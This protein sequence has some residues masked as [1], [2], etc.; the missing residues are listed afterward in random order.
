MSE[1]KIERKKFNWKNLLVLLAGPLTVLIVMLINFHSNELF[2]F[3]N[4]TVA[5]CDMTQ[6][7]IPLLTD[8]KDILSGKAGVFLNFQNAGGM[9]LWGVIFFF[10]ASP[11]TFLVAF[12]KK[13][14]IVYLVNIL[15]ILKLM[16][17]A[18]TAEIYL[19]SCIKKLSPVFAVMLSVVYA[20][21]GYGMLFYQ[22][23]IWLD[24]MYLFP[25]L[26]WS[27]NCLIERKRILPYVIVLTLMM[28]VNYYI[29][30][31]VVLYILLF[32][33]LYCFRY[34]NGNNGDTQVSA[35]FFTG[36]FL[37]ALI[38]AVVW[39]PSFIQ[40][41]SSGRTSSI[42]SNLKN[43]DFFGH[44]QTTI[45][46]LLCSAILPSVILACTMD[47]KHRNKKLN[48]Y[49][50]MLFLLLVP[51]FIEPVNIMWHTGSYMS[52]PARYGFMTIFVAVV[53]IGM[54]LSNDDN[55]RIAEFKS[56]SSTISLI[57]CLL[58]TIGAFLFLDNFVSGNLYTLRNYTE[59]L[60]QSDESFLKLLEMFAVL[61]LIYGAV[62]LFYKKGHLM[63]SSFA[64]LTSAIIIME[65]YSCL[66]IYVDS[67]NKISP[68]RAVNQQD[69]IELADRIDDNS[70]F[71]RVKTSSKLF[72]VNLVGAMG[73]N[74]I[75]HYTS[76]TS[77]D[78]MYM[79][80]QLGYSS[81]W[82]EVGSY[83]GT[84]IS[85]ALL[86][87]KYCITQSTNSPDN[88][89]AN[90]FYEIDKTNNYLPLGIVTSNDLSDSGE[91]PDTDRA[92]IQQSLYEKLL[93]ENSDSKDNKIITKYFPAMSD[94]VISSS[95]TSPYTLRLSG[96]SE[97]TL[98]P[99]SGSLT[100]SFN[101]SGKQ[102]VYFD[103]FDQL[104]T[105]LTE[106][107]NNSF[108]IRVNGI[109][110]QSAYPTQANNGLLKLGTFEN[111]E[112]IVQVSVLKNVSCKSFGVF[113][114]DLDKLSKSVN[115]AKT[116]N[117]T[118]DKGKLSGTY[119]AQKGEKCVV[120][121][122]Y[123]SSLKIKINGEKVS[124]SKVFGD[125]ISFDLKE[126]NNNIVITSVP[127]GF[128]PAAAISIIGIL[129]AVLY[130][131]HGRKI[132]YSETFCQAINVMLIGV[133]III[134][135]AVYIAPCIINIFFG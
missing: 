53:C 35:R 2:P 96:I 60:W 9:N 120:S 7:V 124:C 70:G 49:L 91:L 127:S 37:S 61:A 79:M 69:A 112:V 62:F 10:I 12:V 77:R 48:T 38:S 99:K 22:N 104:S 46:L 128:Y 134:A 94:G 42:I 40:Y 63:K 16:T 27:F 71:Y 88:V 132:K 106:P 83:G 73:Y 126:G 14:Q 28:I 20:F 13:T 92:D 87:M 8:F 95:E 51:I 98:E 64:I 103:C 81:Y 26:L 135:A 66:N 50:I 65:S 122:P 130:K 3:G 80:K 29:S 93:C 76:L 84:E 97:S 15:L 90:R 34:R 118:A 108:T 116:V 5:W 56:K 45:S 58:L 100:Y 55:K 43:A 39:I 107:I 133:G 47:G 72:D 31:M 4:G 33:G 110:V 52:F 117:L 30:Y 86:S 111:E 23:I 41:L 19:R 123:Q 121:I 82:M 17:S 85:D 25:L 21:C 101:V 119:S 115:S 114:V 57:I 89:Y 109:T 78:Y 59:T 125:M 102:T 32:M 24:M 54:Y 131:I 75:S 18:L 68:S 74:S 1:K 129:L 36:S 113:G 105:N 67:P 44:Y 11:F 6:Q